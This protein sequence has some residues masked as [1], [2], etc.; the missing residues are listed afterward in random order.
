M[1]GRNE[2]ESPEQGGDIVWRILAVVGLVFALTLVAAGANDIFQFWPTVDETERPSQRDRS[3][4]RSSGLDP[5]PTT[6]TWRLDTG[7]G[8]SSRPAGFPCTTYDGGDGYV[9][10]DG[11]CVRRPQFNPSS[12]GSATAR[13]ADGSYSYSRNR[14]GTCSGHGGVSS[15]MR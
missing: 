10:T 3:V 4:A 1:S 7:S 8:T 12:P 5:R 15:W 6:T 14:R 13:C 2:G 9:N 11:L